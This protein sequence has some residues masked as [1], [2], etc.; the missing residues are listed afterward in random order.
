V[1]RE[2]LRDAQ[3]HEVHGAVITDRMFR[4]PHYRLADAQAA[5]NPD[6]W[7]YEFAWRSGLPGYGSGHFMEVP[8]V[9]H[10]LGSREGIGICGPDGPAELAD[11]VQ[12]VW[13]AF[14]GGGEPGTVRLPGWSRW[15]P[16]EQRL[17][18]LDLP[19]RLSGDPRP[20]ETK[21]WEAV[22]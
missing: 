22:L 18:V 11:L 4:V 17:M 13:V 20:A 16:A 5:H 2:R 15:T 19:P 6:I 1:Y 9:F 21:V 14:V 7:V 10:T 12:E 3:A 8:F